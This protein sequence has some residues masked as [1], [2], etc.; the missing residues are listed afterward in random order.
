MKKKLLIVLS[1]IFIVFSAVGIFGACETETP[2]NVKPESKTYSVTYETAEGV[3]Y[4]DDNPTSVQTGERVSISFELSV[5]YKA[6]EELPV[7]TVNERERNVS[8]DEET[9]IY[10]VIISNVS[11][12]LAVS[13]SGVVK[14][15]S[16]LTSS[17]SGT[18]ENPF[19][20][21]EP[22]DLVFLAEQ[23]NDGNA[24]TGNTA[25][26]SLE[27]SLDFR[28]EEI[29]IIGDG[30][31]D[32][33][34]FA[35]VFNGNGN[36]IS[37]FVINSSNSNNVGLFGVV[38]AYDGN[39][40]NNLYGGTITNLTIENFS[41]T[42]KSNGGTL[43]CGSLI[44]QSYGAVVSLCNAVNGNIEIYGDA[45][46][47]AYA[48]GLIGL[49]ASYSYPFFSSV[50][51]CH[52]DVE[53]N[54]N[55]GTV[56]VAGGVV[57]YVYSNDETV[58]ATV[59]N[60][61]SEGDVSGSFYA[62]GVVGWLCSYTGVVNCYSTGN[63]SA[64]TTITDIANLEMYCH[65][66]AGGIVAMAQTDSVVADSFA[67][68]SLNSAAK[69]GS[70]YSHTGG[71][72]ANAA[73]ASTGEYGSSS[74]TV[75]NCYYA[76]KGKT[77]EIDLTKTADLQNK[78]HW[79]DFDWDFN[80]GAYP[81]IDTEVHEENYSFTVK[82]DFGSAPVKG[83]NNENIDGTE[84]E[85]SEAY[86]PMSF[87][88]L[89]NLGENGT[90]GIPQSSLIK[91]ENGYS[92]YGYYFDEECTQ[93]V[94]FGYI[95]T[96]NITLYVG[97]ADNKEVADSYYLLVESETG[98]MREVVLTLESD[99]EFKC[100]DPTGN[101]GGVYKYNGKDIIFTNANFARYRYANNL[102]A[103]GSFIFKADITDNGLSI[104]GGR[105]TD[106]STG[107]V[108]Q[109]IT[110]DNPLIAV[111]SSN[112]VVGSYY[113]IKSGKA[114]IYT[115]F[116]NGKGSTN[117]Y[118]DFTYTVD[119]NK[120][121]LTVN[122]E[123]SVVEGELSNG[124]LIKL[125]G[126]NMLSV[127]KYV[128]RYRVFALADMY[129]EFDGA[130]NFTYTYYNGRTNISAQG[131]YELVNEGESIKL[132]NG[133]SACF[134]ESG[135]LVFVGNDVTYTY[136]NTESYFGKWTTSDKQSSITFN[137][138]GKGGNGNA[139]IVFLSEED[140]IVQKEI[141]ELTYSED[142]MN[143]NTVYLYN[144]D[145]VFGVLSY[146]K[147]DIS[148]SGK[149]YDL[150]TSSYYDYTFY[151]A[152][153]YEGEWIGGSVFKI[154]NFNGYGS[155]TVGNVN[156]LEGSLT[157][158][159]EKASYTL[160]KLTLT[161]SVI[162]N[163]KSYKLTYD[164]GTGKITI[165]D[166]TLVRKD[167]LG[168]LTFID[169][170]G[171]EYYFDGKGSLDTKGT[172]TVSENESKKEYKYSIDGENKVA[173][174]YDT[175]EN[176]VGSIVVNSDGKNYRIEINEESSIIREKTLFTGKWALNYAY[177]RLL[178]IGA[179][180]LDGTMSGKLPLLIDDVNVVKDTVFTLVN[181]EYL[182]CT[183]SVT[184]DGATVSEEFY[185]INVA[186]NVFVISTYLN[187]FNYDAEYLFATTPDDMFGTW[188][189]SYLGDEYIF[190][191][192][193]CLSTVHGRVIQKETN[194]DEANAL[195]YFYGY[196]ERKD[197]TGFD[198][199]IFNQSYA[200]VQKVNFNVEENE[201]DVYVNLITNEKF[202][203]DVI[204]SLDDYIIEENE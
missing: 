53:V 49:Q 31:N 101:Y 109:M 196:Y 133:L 81:V 13:V 52:T 86:K 63:V 108:V 69:L 158:N 172:L 96:R 139:K 15:E 174:I 79:H 136:G 68:G 76:E 26:F 29:Q 10:S 130:G 91:G 98:D 61:Y 197:G 112:V 107:S 56:Y 17:G 36:T 22:I 140:G 131:T 138:I 194:A 111:K 181:G 24:G 167:L 62:G 135:M 80:D 145:T 183:V 201:K 88:Y 72:V 77:S 162:Y 204:N 110:D 195:E 59:N 75:Y 137:G 6:E 150:V 165:G 122:G 105:Y 120:V 64:Q 115:F 85:I 34:C 182:M 198:F 74:A 160:D 97:F 169:E 40:G 151:R 5:F 47:F 143:E 2:P 8:F 66:Y 178:E 187:W 58:V 132:S 175:N 147:D 19:L 32:T 117:D 185:V 179:M 170:N 124:A 123:T 180:N 82:L 51:Y 95:P 184:S 35:G 189:N 154:V 99:G 102:D 114:L 164:V 193:G 149:V 78:L 119:G 166:E 113:Y 45:L 188:K 38:Q 4:S 93:A 159:G 94:P 54:C 104:V 30:G 144:S 20:I 121:L 142:L 176:S 50:S 9:G 192:I 23:I 177:G 128:G 11:R 16:K 190:D 48:G 3:K 65:A 129:Y 186:K 127:D 203:L 153:E 39:F 199:L 60:C 152:D 148:L 71:T 12:D 70:E 27:N 141:Y 155:Y 103:Q 171:K 125:N 116:A 202:G 37:N 57:G 25:Y 157:I 200:S 84:I 89:I 33:A 146:S 92:A 156:S 168:E 55:S 173:N 163:K 67:T 46:H 83:D 90:N 87:W 43:I 42:A 73:A 106:A 28:G 191:G 18:E 41:I 126:E 1:C 44:G 100:N 14:A 118:D 134:N 7:V 161:G 21:Q